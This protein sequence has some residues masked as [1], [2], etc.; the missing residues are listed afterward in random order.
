MPQRRTACRHCGRPAT[1]PR[2]LCCRCYSRPEIRRRYLSES[3]LA[4]KSACGDGD[5]GDVYLANPPAPEPTDRLPGP[6]KI[7]VF[8]ERARLHQSIFHPADARPE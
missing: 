5:G 4:K 3:K 7:E 2:G 8:A 1:R 6:N